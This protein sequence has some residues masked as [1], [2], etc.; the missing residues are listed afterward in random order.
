VKKPNG[1]NGT[2][3]AY[4]DLGSMYLRGVVMRFT[5]LNI[6]PFMAVLV[7]FTAC[8]G[9]AEKEAAN[10]PI[11]ENPAVETPAQ[12]EERISQTPKRGLLT[13]AAMRKDTPKSK[14]DSLI[15]KGA[16]VNET[17]AVEGGSVDP[18][19]ASMLRDDNG[20]MANY[21][22]RTYPVRTDS[23][24]KGFDAKNM[25]EIQGWVE[26]L[27]LIEKSRSGKNVE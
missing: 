3:L 10:D 25:A 5:G 26:T 4:I 14:I 15:K 2:A 6:Y 7:L 16:D 18:L 27:E 17:L 12:V 11:P 22:L 13:V 23:I 24:Y 8:S 1:F 21:L 19:L 20:E 9:E